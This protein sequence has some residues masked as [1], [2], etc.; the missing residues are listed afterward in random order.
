MA[1]ARRLQ[2]SDE[3]V[4]TLAISSSVQFSSAQFKIGIYVRAKSEYGNDVA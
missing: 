3:A 4:C 2:Q 1:T